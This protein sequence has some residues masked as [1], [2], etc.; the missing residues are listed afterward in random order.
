MPSRACSGRACRSCATSIGLGEPAN[1]NL[2]VI[3]ASSQE[4]GGF[5][6]AYDQTS[7][8]VQVSY[9]ADPFVILHE[10]A[11]LWFN[12]ALASDRWIEEGFA[13]YYAEQAVLAIGTVDHAPQLSERLL[14]AAVPFNDW[15][16]AGV[17]SSA[18]DAYLYAATLDVAR[19]IADAAG[20]AAMRKVW[21]SGSAGTAAYQPL[22][23]GVPETQAGPLDWRRLLDLLELTTGRS[24]QATWTGSIVTPTQ[25]P[26]LNQRLATQDVY[27]ELVSLAGNWTLPPEIRRYMSNWQFDQA[28]GALDEARQVLRQRALIDS[29]AATELTTPPATLERVFENGSALAA[30]SEARSEVA[31]LGDLAAARQAQTANKDASGFLIGADPNAQLA[32]AREAFARGDLQAAVSQAQSAQKA[33][34][35]GYA[36]QLVRLL[37]LLAGSLGLLLLLAVSVWTMARR[38]KG[39]EGLA[40]AA[41]GVS[42]QVP[43]VSHARSADARAESLA[44]G[45]A[46]IAGSKSRSDTRHGLPWRRAGRRVGGEFRRLGRGR[47]RGGRRNRR[48]EGVRRASRPGRAPR[49]I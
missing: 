5:A 16:A 10:A 31:A 40:G 37:G 7:G 24:F 4:I 49:R 45:I 34:A 35:G 20:P 8:Q 38:S 26:L 14:E 32:A 3:E 12:D 6:G 28:S 25:L 30:A 13:S 1:R 23:R 42:T 36:A 41:S 15:V 47:R 46:A 29:G 19:D 33:W 18:T 21:Q 39:L 9:L 11:H 27:R 43:A 44:D 22:G 17:P 2:T 48:A